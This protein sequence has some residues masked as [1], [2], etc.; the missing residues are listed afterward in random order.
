MSILG[1]RYF[2]TSNAIYSY[3][4]GCRELAV[5]GYLRSRAGSKD[6][7]WP[8]MQTIAAAC[9]CSDTTARKAV[10]IAGEAGLGP[11]DFSNGNRGG[12]AY[13]YRAAEGGIEAP[14]RRAREC[15]ETADK[16][17]FTQKRA[18][19]YGPVAA[20]LQP[21][22]RELCDLYDTHQPYWN[23]VALLKENYREFALL[24]DLYELVRRICRDKS[25]RQLL[26]RVDIV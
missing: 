1:E 20:R 8:S 6:Y 3:G 14:G 11:E 25:C 2:K 9:N 10:E 26:V 22:M 19:E 23:T 12:A 7:C 5:Y 15:A 21:L 13:L 16:G 17:W 18:K 24:S 4:L